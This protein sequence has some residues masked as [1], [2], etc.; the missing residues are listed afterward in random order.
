MKKF[1]LKSTYRDEKGSDFQKKVTQSAIFH[2]Y[3]R[4]SDES[5]FGPE[6]LTAPVKLN[7][8]PIAQRFEDRL[9]AVIGLCAVSI[10][11]V[12]KAERSF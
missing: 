6:Y 11:H 4:F 9:H 2:V 5:N 10:H 7:Q 12:S 3:Y 8:Q 1:S